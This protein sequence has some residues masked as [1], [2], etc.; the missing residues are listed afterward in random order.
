MNLNQLASYAIQLNK[1]GSRDGGKIVDEILKKADSQW[2]KSEIGWDL[3][4]S[5]TKIR[6]QNC[7]KF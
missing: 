3:I 4:E 6:N 2:M 1:L 5:F 7:L